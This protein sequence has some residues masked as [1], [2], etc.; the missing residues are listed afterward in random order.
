MPRLLIALIILAGVT[1][2][3]AGE[4]YQV[5]AAG[6]PF[7]VTKVADTNDGSCNADCSLREAITA[8]N[9]NNNQLTERD[10][11]TFNITGHGMT[12]SPTTPLPV[13]TEPLEIDGSS[14]PGTS[15]S[16]HRVIVLT[17]DGTG[18]AATDD[19]L[20]VSYGV[21]QGTIIRGLAIT[22]W[23]NAIE[24][25]AGSNHVVE[26]TNL[27]IN[28]AGTT[29]AG[30]TR[31]VF[32]SNANSALIGGTTAAH[33][34]I[35]SGNGSGI[36][37]NGSGQDLEISA[38]YIGTN[39]GGTA[40]VANATG[41]V[42]SAHGNTEIGGTLAG[43][44]NVISGNTSYGIHLQGV[45]DTTIYGNYIGYAANGTTLLANG[46]H[47]IRA[48]GTTTTTTTI[49]GTDAGEA[50]RIYSGAGISAVAVPDSPVADE[51]FIRGN[52]IKSEALGINLIKAGEGVDV[53]T[54]ND[55]SD[56]DAGANG[57]QNSP[58]LTVAV[59]GAPGFISGLFPGKPSV[60]Y[61]LDFYRGTGCG[62][63]GDDDGEFHLGSSSTSG[64]IGTG[65]VTFS[66]SISGFVAGDSIT[67]TATSAEG[68]S[69]FSTCITATGQVPETVTVTTE[70][71][72]NDG[73]CNLS[74]CS[75]REAIN[76]T[77]GNANPEVQDIIAFNVGGSGAVR[78]IVVES[79]LPDITQPVKIDGITQ[80]GSVCTDQGRGLWLELAPFEESATVGLT[81]AGVESP[82]VVIRGMAI[83]GFSDAGI[84]VSSSPDT[85][86][87]CN[88][89]GMNAFGDETRPNGTGIFVENSAGTIIGGGGAAKRNVISAN[90]TLGLEIQGD[91]VIVSGNFFGIDDGGA[92]AFPNGVGIELDGASNTTIGGTT[93]AE[94]NAIAHNFGPG[95]RVQGDAL[96]GVRIIG[97]AIG[98]GPTASIEK[99]NQAGIVIGT[100]NLGTLNGGLGFGVQVGGVEPGERNRIFSSNAFSAIEVQV[101]AS[102]VANRHVIRGNEIKS[103]QLGIDLRGAGQNPNLVTEN[104]ALDTD[105]GPNGQQNFPLLATATGGTPGS[106]TGTMN[107]KASTQYTLDFYRGGG[108]CGTAGTRDGEV[109]LG[110]TTV[111]TNGAGTVPIAATLD[112]GF[113]AGS[114]IT[115]T[116][117]DP[118]GNTSEFS[119]CV[120]AAGPPSTTFEVN[121][122]NDADDGNCNVS[123]C[124][125]REAIN[126]A[127]DN[128][129][130]TVQ[131]DITFN[132]PGGGVHVIA[133][134]ATELP[135]VTDAVFIDGLA[136]P[137]AVCTNE[138][139][140]ILVEIH[141]D[142]NLHFVGLS[143]APGPGPGVSVR[144]VAI[145]GFEGS[146]IRATGSRPTISCNN[147]GLKA[148]GQA[149]DGNGGAGIVLEGTNLGA[150]GND[151]VSARNLIGSNGGPGIE[152]TAGTTSTFVAFNYIGVAGDG[153]TP[154]PNGG[155]GI[156]SLFSSS[157]TAF[158]NVIAANDAQ[159][160]YVT[161][162]SQDFDAAANFIGY[163][164]DGTTPMP[165]GGI[166]VELRQLS[167]VNSVGHDIGGT[168]PGH[169]NRIYA[170]N[171][172]AVEVAAAIGAMRDVAIRG[173]SITVVGSGLG[174]A[175]TPAGENGADPTDNDD[176]DADDGPNHLQNYPLLTYAADGPDV[177][178]G[179]LH[180]TPNSDFQLEFFA[181]TTCGT[182]LDGERFL[183]SIEVTT[184]GAGNA[185]FEEESPG[186]IAIGEG[187]TA[188]AT[189]G[190][191]NTSEFSVCI[192]VQAPTVPKT[193]ASIT[194]DEAVAGALDDVDVT[195]TGSGFVNGDLVTWNGVP[196]ATTWVSSTTLTFVATVDLIGA[197]MGNAV[198]GV[199]GSVDTVE[200]HVR[201][202]SSDVD[203]SGAADANDALLLLL[204]V[205]GINIT[206]GDCPA[207]ADQVDGPAP[208]LA[209]VIHIK[210]EIVG[211][212]APL[213]SL[214]Q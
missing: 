136:Q 125:L 48:G 63:P 104:D 115:A 107:S 3:A 76:R 73:I 139:R 195:L 156:S 181:G 170:E 154:R 17:L 148:D 108:T 85:V 88:Y 177:I 66:A 149:A 89:V 87:E 214:H 4:V 1:I 169:F 118:N 60:G 162:K 103:S 13:I 204:M 124:S 196:V 202:S 5:R 174:I 173:N 116:A 127:N 212:V 8:A 178:H 83:G 184:D 49:G 86:I 94:E 165:N 138:A 51:V 201:R 28:A 9:A 62:S 80:P 50:N 46:D 161:S 141:G 210:R 123:H 53:F 207:D 106:V 96:E 93:A 37:A 147:I 72:N 131:D 142:E 137:G 172:N 110:S 81:V 157:T 90:T 23:D 95:I 55:A 211:L 117:T 27:G 98:Y 78:T 18:A 21:G 198:I 54:P 42:R 75:L 109:Y 120:T 77:N 135:A 74:H 79:T 6:Q 32:V 114:V 38:N 164:A 128:E 102:T 101:A 146:G 175:L 40:A 61:T 187:I 82:G 12:I 160:I 151:A 155:A 91:G 47:A 122:A 192:L 191:N 41:I 70:D 45:G 105:A 36:F 84:V 190:S 180:S 159:G 68:T 193:I 35:I 19:G 64:A 199:I 158:M 168:Q 44:R 69:E 112:A 140:S 113:A 203:C 100:K 129:N 11:I 152:L 65:L 171:T 119:A 182:T 143:L 56:A 176:L 15:C 167:D 24:L 144:G 166:A 130:P 183:G 185:T 20:V 43:E 200:F 150:I 194:P 2:S 59:A 111:T 33:R 126:A 209:D 205:A 67:A 7:V 179:S 133:L 34:N 153:I 26:C 58:S 29:A 121:S 163:A 22:N 25:L 57:L 213:E 30:N 92:T 186:G 14:Q 52:R 206:T 99:P 208:T 39:A 145:T 31:G 71:D 132:I 134:G 97:N 189:D 10:I 16:S 197:T 188:T